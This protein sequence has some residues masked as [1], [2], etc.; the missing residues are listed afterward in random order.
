MSN[1]IFA[2]IANDG[3]Q[4]GLLNRMILLM[5]WGFWNVFSKYT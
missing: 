1:A 4:F 3:G 5:Q 2:S